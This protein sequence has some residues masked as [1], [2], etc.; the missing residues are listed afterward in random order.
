MKIYASYQSADE[1]FCARLRTE[2]NATPDVSVYGAHLP[3]FLDDKSG[4]ALFDS[5]ELFRTLR[6]PDAVFMVLSPAYFADPWYYQE[7][8]A[9][10]ALECE[11]KSDD[12]II[13]LLIDGVTVAQIPHFLRDRTKV[14]FQ[15]GA[16]D[17]GVR[18]VK[19]VLTQR[20]KRQ[21]ADVFIV[22]GHG[23]AKDE[24]ARFVTQMGLHPTILGEQTARSGTIIE[25][26]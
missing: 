25:R 5:R 2:L 10:F 14:A 6:N 21:A 17:D 12:F 1:A 19:D 7:M 20:K 11:L 22:H 18:Q 13:P 9:L 3:T 23:N 15:G 24:V 4:R 26:L 8:P 16:F